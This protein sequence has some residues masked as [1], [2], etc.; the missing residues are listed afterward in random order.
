MNSDNIT[1]TAV[2]TNYPGLCEHEPLTNE[3]L[4]EIASLNSE[5]INGLSLFALKYRMLPCTLTRSW[6]RKDKQSITNHK[7]QDLYHA[8]RLVDLR[9]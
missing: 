5:K 8:T 9:R 1:S 6:N 2:F 4:F 7:E 3:N